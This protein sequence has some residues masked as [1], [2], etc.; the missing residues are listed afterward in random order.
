MSDY[1][2]DRAALLTHAK[3]QATK[4]VQM[5]PLMVELKRRM[6]LEID[7]DGHFETWR[8]QGG[9][10]GLG[11]HEVYKTLTN[12]ELIERHEAAQDIVKE[13]R[14]QRG[15]AAGDTAVVE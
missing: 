10:E 4:L 8:L 7:P 3:E 12:D 11:T 5:N 9:I 15:K 2:Y 6:G 13:I 14:R 1:I